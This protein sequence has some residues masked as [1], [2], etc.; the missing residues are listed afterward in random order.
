MD[1]SKYPYIR[2]GL[3][4]LWSKHGF[5]SKVYGSIT[6]EV[7]RQISELKKKGHRPNLIRLGTTASRLF[8]YEHGAREGRINLAP[9]SYHDIKIKYR[10]KISGVV[11]E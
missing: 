8:A 7:D 10:D 3:R 6:S 4:P 11:V 9:E 1:F 2:D 5:A